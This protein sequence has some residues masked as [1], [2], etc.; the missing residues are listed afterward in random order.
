MSKRRPRSEAVADQA[1]RSAKPVVD[2]EEEMEKEP[3][4]WERYEHLLNASKD[5]LLGKSILGGSKADEQP[6]QPYEHL[7]HDVEEKSDVDF[8]DHSSLSR[9]IASFSSSS[10]PSALASS[11]TSSSSRSASSSSRSESLFSNH[12][13]PLRRPVPSP[14]SV[15]V[16][17]GDI[18][19][20][21]LVAPAY[22]E[23]TL[24]ISPELRS[25]I[26]QQRMASF[27]VTET[28]ILKV[29]EENR[30]PLSLYAVQKLL[31]VNKR[32]SVSSLLEIMVA[33]SKLVKTL[34]PDKANDGTNRYFLY[35]LRPT[36]TVEQ[37]QQLLGLIPCVACWVRP[38]EL[39][40]EPCH[41]FTLCRTCL[42]LLLK[43]ECPTCRARIEN[44]FSVY[45]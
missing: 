31:D 37:T 33:E 23:P 29:F 10:S 6:W 22:T 9:P 2:V 25:R 34:D 40:L 26:K 11:S 1:R 44:T 12:R 38:R 30:R 18:A 5:E 15:V 45:L 17:D 27:S 21:P 13:H 14:R 24:N 39:I 19:E 3:L 43:H 7:L 20:S 8:D 28:Q 36:I 42:P 32:T 35:S 41:H 4:K 16:I